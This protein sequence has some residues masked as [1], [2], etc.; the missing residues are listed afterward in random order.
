MDTVYIA[1]LQRRVAWL[2]E[3]YHLTVDFD[4]ERL[5][6][7]QIFELKGIIRR[8][9]FSRLEHERKEKC[10]EPHARN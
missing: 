5:L 7:D 8:E 4:E 10:H 1:F 9:A 2:L 6:L 3:Q